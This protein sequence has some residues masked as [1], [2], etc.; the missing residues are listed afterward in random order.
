MCHINR[1]GAKNDVF[2]HVLNDVMSI[3]PFQEDPIPDSVAKAMRMQKGKN[4]EVEAH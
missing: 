2:W 1:F 4:M 3:G